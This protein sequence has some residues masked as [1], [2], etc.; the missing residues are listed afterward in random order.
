[1]KKKILLFLIVLLS[2][3]LILIIF[4]LTKKPRTIWITDNEY[5]YTKAISYIVNEKTNENSNKDKEDFQIFTDFQG[6]G[7]EEKKKLKYAYIWIL[8]EAYYVSDNKLVSSSSSSMLYKFM[9]ENDEVVSYEV[10]KDGA[11]YGSSLKK[12]LPDSIEDLVLNFNMGDDRLKFKVNEH[13]SYLPSDENEL[14]TFSP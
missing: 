4:I 5:L 12:M 3:L 14:T 8:D 7:V 6:F 9:F 10:P 2:L 11:E 13:Y 1:M